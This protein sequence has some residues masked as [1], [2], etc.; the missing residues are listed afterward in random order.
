MDWSYYNDLFGNG[1]NIEKMKKLFLF[2]PLIIVIMITIFCLVFLLQGKDP[3][4]PPSAL[5]YKNLP[6]LNMISLFDASNVIS[7]KDLNGN[8]M[9]INFFA[10]WCAPCKVEHP[11][12]FEIKKNYPNI[13]LVG[14]NYKDKQE[15]AINYL[16]TMGNPYDYV[17]VDNKGL[18]GLELG[19][20]GLPETFIVNSK[21]IITYKHLGP[22]TKKIITNEVTPFIQ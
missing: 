13:L 2:I 14:I 12:F 15:E 4:K 19:V 10:S 5:L 3:N 9:L 1:W 22:L 20:F 6:E 8:I 18:I 16:N 17:G 21:G 7:N 11:L